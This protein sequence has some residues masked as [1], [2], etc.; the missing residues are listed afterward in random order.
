[1]W[2]DQNGPRIRVLIWLLLALSAGAADKGQPLKI[3]TGLWEVTTTVSTND[4]APIPAGLL[5]KL[6]PEQRQR[7]Q[8]R[9]EARQSGTTKTAIA[10]RCVS[11]KELETGVPF[12]PDVKS[13]S[14]ETTASTRTK[15]TADLRCAGESS[16][17]EVSKGSL[18]VEALTSESVRGSVVIPATH[19]DDPVHSSSIFTAKWMGPSCK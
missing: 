19:S 4:E 6:T 8:E 1:M 12:K 14:W 5:E 18:E 7:I 9:M 13:C 17:E 16:R 11:R 3:K 2:A 10:R 15:M